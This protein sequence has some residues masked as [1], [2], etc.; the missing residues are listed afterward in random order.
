METL[1]D[2]KYY[3]ASDDMSK[4][5]EQDKDIDF[6]LLNDNTSI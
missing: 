1:F 4:D 5:L 6:Q 3:A 2:E